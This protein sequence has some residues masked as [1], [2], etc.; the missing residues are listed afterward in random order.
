MVITDLNFGEMSERNGFDLAR[1]IKKRSSDMKVYLCSDADENLLKDRLSVD[2]I[3]PKD[4]M[5]YHGLLSFLEFK[6]EKL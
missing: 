4:A 1:E 2:A 6:K 3:I 5:S